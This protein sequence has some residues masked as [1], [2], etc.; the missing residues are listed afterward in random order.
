MFLSLLLLIHIPLTISM[1]YR[2]KK[3]LYLVQPYK[4]GEVK[5]LPEGDIGFKEADGTLKGNVTTL[6]GNSPVPGVTITATAQV[7][8]DY[9]TYSGTTTSLG[10]YT[11]PEVF[12]GE[13]IN[14]AI[15]T[16]TPEYKDHVFQPASKEL[17]ISP[18]VEPSCGQFL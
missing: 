8:G 6:I 18:S 4:T 3:H 17:S 5:F 16:L 15:Y 9:Y 11:I 13:D 1:E 10:E 2:E 12:Y 7:E 14:G